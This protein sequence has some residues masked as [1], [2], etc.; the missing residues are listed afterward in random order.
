MAEKPPRRVVP[1]GL[2]IGVSSPDSA[3]NWPFEVFYAKPNQPV[4]CTV[5]SR[6]PVWCRVHWTGH[7]TVPCEGDLCPF[8]T[9]AGHPIQ[10]SAYLAVAVGQKKKP[11]LLNLPKACERVLTDLEARYCGLR[12]VRLMIRRQEEKHNGRVSVEFLDWWGDRKLPP[13]FNVL[14]WLYVMWN[15]EI[16]LG[17]TPELPPEAPAC[18]E[19]RRAI[20]KLARDIG[21]PPAREG[22]G[23]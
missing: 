21:K 8:S 16:P 4:A 12:G 7:E 18:E 20:L 9:D 15:Y 14:F 3:A 1:P 23:A 2:G 19:D 13:A 22:G 11:C 6:S 5:L 17:L 10:F